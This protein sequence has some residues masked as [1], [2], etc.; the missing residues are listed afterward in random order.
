MTSTSSSARGRRPR[1]SAWA[2]PS[3]SRSCAATSASPGLGIDPKWIEEH[4]GQI[5]HMFHLAAIYDMTADEERN[6]TL[7]NGGTRHAVEV[8]NALQVGHLHHTSSVAAAG[9]LP[10][11]VHRG[12]VRRGPGPR[13][14]LPPHEVRVRAHRPRGVRGAVARLPPGDG[15]RALRDGRDGQGRRAVLPLQGD[16]AEREAARSCCRCSARGWATR[17]SSRSTSSPTRW[18]TSPT[19]RASTAA[20]STSSARSRSDDR[21]PQHLRARSP[22]GRARRPSC[23]KAALTPRASCPGANRLL[24]DLGIPPDALDYADFTA[25]FDT[26]QTRKALEGSGISVP[27]SRATRRRCGATGRSTSRTEP[28]A[29]AGSWR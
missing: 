21:R 2:A 13:P 22:A 15:A 6:E 23:P 19:S 3:A 1:P 16:Q 17:T 5:D 10:G 25:R 27:R 20:P 9:P 11:H 29:G 18:P 4:K 7:N 28:G 14:P 24:G 8:A 12:H 26:T